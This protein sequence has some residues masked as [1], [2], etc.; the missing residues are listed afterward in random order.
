M[1]G[2]GAE[3]S[4][5]QRFKR[6]APAVLEASTVGD[7][8]GIGKTI[9]GYFFGCDERVVVASRAQ[10]REQRREIAFYVARLPSVPRHGE[11]RVENARREDVAIA[12]REKGVEAM[13][14]YAQAGDERGE[15][16]RVADA[17]EADDEDVGD[18]TLLSKA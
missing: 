10:S 4:N 3:A 8:R 2:T 6:L 14:G 13:S 16:R 18:G 1:N 11:R 7:I 17:V 9:S 12:F 5:Q 15:D